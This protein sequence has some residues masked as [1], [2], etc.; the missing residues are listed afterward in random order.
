MHVETSSKY[1]AKKEDKESFWITYDGLNN[2]VQGPRK[3]GQA[4]QLLQ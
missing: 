2:E 4:L 1:I 3:G